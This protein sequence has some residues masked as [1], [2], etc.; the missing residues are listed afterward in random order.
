MSG[1][2]RW[3]LQSAM[4]ANNDTTLDFGP[5]SCQKNA[6]L[7]LRFSF[8]SAPPAF[9]RGGGGTPPFPKFL[10]LPLMY[11]YNILYYTIYINYVLFNQGN[12]NY[13]I[14]IIYICGIHLRFG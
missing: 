14:T 5:C 11:V 2:N 4:C 7:A 10:D 8:S 13:H 1:L 9:A 12:T 6:Y 3:C